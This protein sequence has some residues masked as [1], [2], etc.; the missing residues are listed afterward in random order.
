MSTLIQWKMKTK[1][2]PIYLTAS[3]KGLV[4]VMTEVSTAPVIKSILGNQAEIVNLREAVTQLE[5]YFQGKR[6]KFTLSLKPEGTDFQKKVWKQLQK[7]PFG[8]T[9]SYKEIAIRIKNK[10]AV[11]AV[12]SANGKNP[13]FIIVP[14]HRV[15][16][17][18]GSLGGYAGGLEVKI[19]LLKLEKAVNSQ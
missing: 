12:G 11:R 15:I 13:F 16:A 14:C 2:G 7:I 1:I 10:K 9:C 4:S 6:K 5:E 18:D 3:E 8:K 17:S 19:K